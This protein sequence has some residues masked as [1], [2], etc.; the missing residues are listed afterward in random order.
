MKTLV[1]SPVTLSIASSPAHLA[2]VRAALERFCQGMGFDEAA[3]GQV[4][5]SVDEALT[6]II[7]HAY[8]GA[9]DR[10]VDIEMVPRTECLLIRIR[11]YG[12]PVDRSTIRSRDLGDVRPGGLGVHIM[13]Q[14]MDGL[15]YQPAEGGGTVLTM[16]KKLVPHPK[17][18]P[19]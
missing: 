9:E 7:R 18:D 12:R 5:L 15:D 8:E 4:V 1:E 13:T 3:T 2:I 16:T 17:A 14:C 10:R 19:P 6:N 11:D